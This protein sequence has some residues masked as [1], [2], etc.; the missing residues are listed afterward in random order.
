MLTQKLWFQ[1]GSPQSTL[2]AAGNWSGLSPVSSNGS[3]NGPSQVSSPT[4]ATVGPNDAWDLF[5]AAAGQL[6]RLKM[7]GEGPPKSRGL[8]DPH[9]S[10]SSF[11][12]LPPVKKPNSGFCS[13]QCLSSNNFPP[14]TQ[15]E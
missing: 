12:Q 13:N 11:H 15:V 4:A 2:V 8:I 10:F 9:R 3:P 7:N 6:A 14:A 5:Y 1:S